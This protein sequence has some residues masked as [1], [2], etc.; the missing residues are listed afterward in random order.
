MNKA[1]IVPHTAT[2]SSPFCASIALILFPMQSVEIFD[3]PYP[4]FISLIQ[5]LQSRNDLQVL[6]IDIYHIITISSLSF[7]FYLQIGNSAKSSMPILELGPSL[8]C[9]L[10]NVLTP[11]L[12]VMRVMM[13]CYG[14]NVLLVSKMT[15]YELSSVSFL[16]HSF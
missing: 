9:I 15:V 14:L 12:C 7:L 11:I 6:Y 10:H 5:F 8:L 13:A 1:P 3:F 16:K 2:Q 4:F